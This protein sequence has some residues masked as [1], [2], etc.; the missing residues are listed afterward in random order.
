MTFQNQVNNNLGLAAA[1]LSQVTESNH[2]F[3]E[4][5]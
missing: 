5:T 1:K 4:S 3:K 2:T